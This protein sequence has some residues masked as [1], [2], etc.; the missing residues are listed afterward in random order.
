MLK[1]KHGMEKEKYSK[2]AII[3]LVI[4]IIWSLFPVYW[5]W[6]TSLKSQKEIYSMTP[7]LIPMKA[8]LDSYRKLI[9]GENFL[10]SVWNSVVVAVAVTAVSI[11][12]SAFAAYAFARV[13]FKGRGAWNTSILYAYL[14]PRSIMFI[15][16][17]VLIT[18]I[19]LKDKLS[20]LMV[21]YPTFTVPYAVWMITSYFRSIPKELEEAAEIDGCTKWQSMF[22]I[23][24]PL[25]SPGIA[26]TAIFCFTLCWSEYQY[27]LVSITKSDL[28]TITLTLSNMVV[29]DVYAWGPLMAGSIVATLPVL[30]MYTAMSKYLVSGLTVGAVK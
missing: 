9:F 27:A 30:L 12:V 25:A 23:V 19:G 11:A 21:M 8:S 17:C 6:N 24:F 29:A 3:V 15:P 22:R 2:A 7:T 13:K 14:M 28:Q 5:T 10:K 18:N 26:A 16:L 20:G 1:K 4:L